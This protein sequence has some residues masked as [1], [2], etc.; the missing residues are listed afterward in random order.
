MSRILGLIEVDTCHIC[1]Q[2]AHPKFL[3]P[4][5]GITACVYCV[6]NIHHEFEQHEEAEHERNTYFPIGNTCGAAAGIWGDGEAAEQPCGAE[7]GTSSGTG[8]TC[9]NSGTV[10]GDS[11]GTGILDSERAALFAI[12]GGRTSTGSYAAIR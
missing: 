7:S 5:Q 10:H 11:A 8:S 6:R 1:G 12:P 2:D 4:W 9:A 3:M